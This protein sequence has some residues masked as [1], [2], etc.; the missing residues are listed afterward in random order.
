MKDH[1]PD[2]DPSV[3]W[4]HVFDPPHARPRKD[5]EPINAYYPAKRGYGPHDPCMGDT[6]IRRAKI[7][8]ALEHTLLHRDLTNR[9]RSEIRAFL[10]M[11]AGVDCGAM[12]R[13]RHALVWV[14]DRATGLIGQ[15]SY[16]TITVPWSERFRV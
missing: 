9:D 12:K 8:N 13:G 6:K 3:D 1:E 14:C 5:K 2:T 16:A 4:Q 7:V 15:G 10:A 11:M